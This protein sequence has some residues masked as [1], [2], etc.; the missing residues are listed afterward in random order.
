MTMFLLMEVFKVDNFL[1]HASS[2][3]LVDQSTLPEESTQIPKEECDYEGPEKLLP[4]TNG[5]DSAK[6]TNGNISDSENNDNVT[7][8]TVMFSQKTE[9][10]E[11]PPQ[12]LI[13][14]FCPFSLN[15]R[16]LLANAECIV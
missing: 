7:D 5:I 2:Q 9:F 12:V 4:A 16:A 6:T 10:K 14:Q 13:H 1:S 8:E 11:T 15:P 3:G